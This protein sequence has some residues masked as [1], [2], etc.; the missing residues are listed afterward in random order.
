[1]RK[2]RQVLRLSYEMKASDRA[3]AK[4][5]KISRRSIVDYKVRANAANLEWPL[6][7][8]LDDAQL[9][10]LLYPQINPQRKA[11]FP[12]PNW[13][14]VHQALKQKGA[15]LQVL[16][17]E[18]LALNP[19]GMS[20]SHF[21]NGHREFK[22]T[23]KRSMRQVHVAGD[24]VFVDYVGPTMKIT[25][26]STGEINNAQIFVGV[27]GASGFIYA[28]ASWGQTLPNW[29][30]SHRKMFEHFGGVPNAVVCDNLKA[31][32]TR[33]NKNNPQINDTYQDLAEHYGTVIIPARPYMPKDKAHAE[34][35]VLIIE[36]WVIFVLR[37]RIFTSLM[38]LNNAIKEL[39]MEANSRPFQKIPGSRQSTF[40]EIDKPALRQLPN[41]PYE[42]AEFKK[43]RVGPDYHIELDDRHFYSV[44]NNLVRQE[45]DIR[46]SANTVE[47]LHRNRRVAIHP[48]SYGPG[49]T[50][51]A[52]HM[53]PNHRYMLTWDAN[54]ELDWALS[55]G[56]NVHAF[57]QV[58]FAQAGRKD[59]SMRAANSLK[60]IAKEFGTQR[61]ELACERGLKIGAIKISSIRSILN[62][63]LDQHPTPS[64]TELEADF[65]HIN[66][67]GPGYYH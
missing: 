35:G 52:E 23:L 66:I 6:P 25:S 65:D 3:I 55:I 12:L 18:Y 16:H 1:M 17:E 61:L 44:P 22:K 33:A 26:P 46:Y 41:N 43:C 42:F 63:N 7:E 50:T 8:D 2:I 64:P 30:E 29:I 32:V 13:G 49:K 4:S 21:C 37:N 45:V 5:L 20:Y 28:D 36:R 27:L 47:V 11:R 10:K 53:D 54:T 59:L 38:D 51:N 31:A 14:E 24:K 9:E 60:S 56:S 67:R 39:L 62:T 57:L 40:D 48:R 58:L 19:A 15:T 34:N